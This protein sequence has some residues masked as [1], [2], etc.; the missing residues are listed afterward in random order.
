MGAGS[1]LASSQRPVRPLPVPPARSWVTCR[2]V[3]RPSSIGGLGLFAAEEIKAGGLCML[4]GGQ[5]L[6]GDQF[7]H[8]RR[9]RDR[10]SAL[11]VGEG[12]HL[13]Q[14][15][16]DLARFGNHSCDP[17]L[18]LT[19]A[20]TVVARRRLV[21]GDEATFDYALATADDGW[22][23][24]CRCGTT[25]CRGVVTGVDWRLPALQARYAG[26]F[27]PFIEGLI[28]AR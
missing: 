19:S 28:A 4:L 21:P 7:D 14:D 5:L 17:N 22:A 10:W 25:V 12:W 20:T 23:M 9:T 15:E 26:H 16:E 11:V 1:S 6:D 27:S 18:W 2:L 13:L 8:V 24:E 3:V